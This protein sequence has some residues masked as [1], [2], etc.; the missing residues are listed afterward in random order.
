[1]HLK[2]L[3]SSFSILR[4]W[5]FWIA[6][7]TQCLLSCVSSMW[8]SFACLK[9]WLYLLCWF[10]FSIAFIN[11]V[12]SSMLATRVASSWRRDRT[13]MFLRSF[14]VRNAFSETNWSLFSRC[15]AVLI[16]HYAIYVCFCVTI[17]VSTW[18]SMLIV[19]NAFYSCHCFIVILIS[20]WFW[21][22]STSS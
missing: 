10:L 17:C 22:V 2:Q 8:C 16:K 21:C 15:E 12:N 20:F 9:S 5:R 3:I 18:F 11:L 1:M 7:I 6:S 4:S 14:R 13:S 19:A